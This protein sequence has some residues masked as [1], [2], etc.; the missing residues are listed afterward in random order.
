M[1]KRIILIVVLFLSLTAGTYFLFLSQL[2]RKDKHYLE[3]NIN[4][5]H[6]REMIMSSAPKSKILVMYENAY[7]H[8]KEGVSFLT[9]I[10][11]L[12]MLIRD[13]RKKRKGVN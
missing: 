4:N 13:I 10:L 1:R 11:T 3:E 7:E 5:N 8:V 12:Y 6:Q 2:K 9:S